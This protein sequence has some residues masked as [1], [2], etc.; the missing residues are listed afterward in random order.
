MTCLVQVDLKDVSVGLRINLLANLY[1]LGLLFSLFSLFG[2]QCFRD[3]AIENE[4]AE[5]SIPFACSDLSGLGRR[6]EC[7]VC[8]CLRSAYGAHTFAL[9]ER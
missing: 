8:S 9:Y 7:E 4:L 3:R 1:A 2:M 5:A 6:L